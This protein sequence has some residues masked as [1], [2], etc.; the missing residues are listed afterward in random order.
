MCYNDYNN[1][2]DEEKEKASEEYDPSN[3]LNKGFRF[4]KEKS[5]SQQEETIT[6]RVK[7]RRQKRYDK[8]L[9]YTPPN[10]NDENNDELIDIPD[11]SP[12]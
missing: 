10:S 7:L 8:E 2:T 4:I 11:K 12:L 5:K 3:L 6:E 9:F 1:I